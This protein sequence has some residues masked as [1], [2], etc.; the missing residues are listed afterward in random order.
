MQH[1][2]L[3]HELNIGFFLLFFFFWETSPTRIWQSSFFDLV[4]CQ[5]AFTAGGWGGEGAHSLPWWR[6]LKTESISDKMKVSMQVH[7]IRFEDS[8]DQCDSYSLVACSKFLAVL[9]VDRFCFYMNPKAGFVPSAAV[10]KIAELFSLFS[11]FLPKQYFLKDCLVP[12]PFL[13]C[14]SAHW[15]SKAQYYLRIRSCCTEG[16]WTF[17]LSFDQPLWFLAKKRRNSQ[18]PPAWWLV[19]HWHGNGI[20]NPGQCRSDSRIEV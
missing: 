9:F 1:N 10:L 7:Q 6:E 5:W 16:A 8:G 11:P 12:L 14:S 13:S 17:V 18:N 2:L 15:A 20:Q 4:F 3:T 19:D